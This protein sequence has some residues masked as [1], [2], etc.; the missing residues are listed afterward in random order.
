MLEA[1]RSASARSSLM[2][3]ESGREAQ[4][5]SERH[6]ETQRRGQGPETRRDRARKRGAREEE[7]D[8]QSHREIE[9]CQ[10]SDSSSRIGTAIQ[11]VCEMP[12]RED[13]LATLHDSGAMLTTQRPH[14]RHQFLQR[15]SHMPEPD[16]SC[17]SCVVRGW[18]ADAAAA[19]AAFFGWT[20][21]CRAARLQRVVLWLF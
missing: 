20:G 7:R 11:T 15:C 12:R 6:R 5:A 1:E 18:P 3:V 13:V 2:R 16:P 17:P 10:E 8:R 14:K 21:S 19:Q 9:T 4:T